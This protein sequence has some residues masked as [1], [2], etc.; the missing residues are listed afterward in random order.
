[1]GYGNKVFAFNH[2]QALLGILILSSLA[3]YVFKKRRSRDLIFFSIAWFFL[4]LLPVS[5][6]YPIKSYMA[7]HWL[8]L[9]SI[10]FFLI[11]AKGLSYLYKTKSFRIF[12]LIFITVL[13]ILYSYLNIRQNN[14][15][16]DPVVFFER[17]IKYAPNSTELYN[18]L[19]LAYDI[20]G[21][22]YDTIPLYKKAIELDPNN[23]DAYSSLGNAYKKRKR[24]QEAIASYKKAIGLKPNYAN[25]YFNLGVAYYDMGTKDEAIASYK[26]AIE[27]NPN[28]GDAQNNLAVVYYDKKQYA[29]AAKHCNRALELGFKVHP[30]FLK[31]LEPYRK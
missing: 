14:Y 23:S 12:A 28:R 29:I 24:Y 11:L 19:G 21:K 10:G 16:Q 30:G 9:P 26:K 15:W 7:E 20:S 8:Y 1:M 27:L 4:A 18:N 2:P 22:E 3:I 13:L 17:A 25:P 6:L 31:A 5:N